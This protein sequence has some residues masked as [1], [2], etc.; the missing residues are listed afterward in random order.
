MVELKCLNIALSLANG[1]VSRATRLVGLKD[2]RKRF[3][4]LVKKHQ[5]DVSEYK[6]SS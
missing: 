6:K 1:E 4:E 2:N 3:Y 5:I